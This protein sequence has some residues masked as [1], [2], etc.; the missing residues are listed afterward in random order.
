MIGETFGNYRLVLRLGSGAMGT[1]F[2][3]EHERIA[4]RAAVKV[5]SPEFAENADILRRFFAEARATSLIDHPAIVEVFDCGVHPDGRRP[6]IVMEYLRGETLAAYLGRTGPLAWQEACAI[7]QQLADALAAAHRRRI[8][9]RDVK[10]AN[11]M[12]IVDAG[13]G[14]AG[15]AAAIKVLDFGIAK[16]LHD[17]LSGVRTH[18]GKLLGTPEYMAP[19]QASGEGPIDERTDIYAL[20]CVLYEMVCGQPPFAAKS[21][22]DLVLAH[23][24]RE[25]PVASSLA[26]L[27]PALDRLIARMLSKPPPDRPPSMTAVVEGLRE[28][29]APPSPV[30]A[31]HP[32]EAPTVPAVEPAWRRSRARRWPLWRLAFAGALAA[33]AAA[34][35]TWQMTGRSREG[36]DPGLAAPAAP[37][38][39]ITSALP[40][41]LESVSA[42]P[43]PPPPLSRPP[44]SPTVSPPPLLEEAPAE[45]ASAPVPAETPPARAASRPRSAAGGSP[46]I[47]QPAAVPPRAR[48]GRR[49]PEV[50]AD[51]IVD[52]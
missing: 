33:V 11:V 35:L 48:A 5:L 16:L 46:A 24:W 26:E 30:A 1:V 15:G 9:H 22:S 38:R 18:P 29:V 4:R 40:Q 12:R 23:R 47:R 17:T 7:A 49:P 6:Y 32:A 39:P 31:I 50:D 21:L 10:P 34:G 37:Q 36:R 25:A 13:A 8:V 28:V 27:P 51:G 44:V 41:M 19:E 20:G 52:L 3:G 43:L 14:S 45:T 2:L 42:A